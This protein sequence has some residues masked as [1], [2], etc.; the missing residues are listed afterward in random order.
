MLQSNA[1]QRMMAQSTHS[2]SSFPCVELRLRDKGQSQSIKD[3]HM[4]VSAQYLV[5][6]ISMDRNLCYIRVKI[7]VLRAATI[8]DFVVLVSSVA[9]CLSCPSSR[10]YNAPQFDF[11]F[12]TLPSPIITCSHIHLFWF[13]RSNGISQAQANR[14]IQRFK[15]SR[16]LYTRQGIVIF[17]FII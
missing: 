17:K 3:Q 8:I 4:H 10:D 13:V 5:P 9:C 16:K 7:G 15:T 1:V 6:T 12:L 14:A 2:L 11:K